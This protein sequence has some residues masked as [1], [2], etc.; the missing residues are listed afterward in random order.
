[1]DVPVKYPLLRPYMN[2]HIRRAVM[3]VLSHNQ[4]SEGPNVAAFEKA[5]RE[6]FG[7]F[8]VAVNSGTSALE[9]A[10]DLMGWGKGNEVWVPVLTC[11]ATNIPLARR[12][13]KL[14]FMDVDP[15]TLNPI[16]PKNAG[17]VVS[18][19]LNGIK[20]EV[21]ADVH[22]CAQSP[23]AIHYGKFSCYSFQAIKQ[24]TTGDGGLLDCARKNDYEV[25]RKLRWFGIG[26]DEPRRK[27]DYEPH[28]IREIFADIEDPGYKFQMNDIAGAMGLAGLQSYDA[29][30][31]HRQEL[32]QEYKR[33]LKNISG[34]KILQ[35]KEMYHYSLGIL[36]ERREDFAR[37]LREHGVERNLIQIRN[38]LY[39]VFGGKR[40]DLPNM[41]ALEGKDL[42][43]PLNH[44]IS[45][46]DVGQ[47]CDW[48]KG[49]W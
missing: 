37:M 43:L 9:L 12:G 25:A 26:R 3:D 39:K 48:I 16:V 7:G 33:G 15:D 34:I 6:K 1:M 44:E 18:V 17:W 36:V 31:S 40:Q 21:A 2:S 28:E 27:E 42:F 22:D 46:S 30:M 14:K 35:G 20:N 49:G 41:N 24:F 47:I 8:P 19:D 4:I 23:G 5:F 29:L 32:F 45:T 10:Y 38:D 11:V 13:V